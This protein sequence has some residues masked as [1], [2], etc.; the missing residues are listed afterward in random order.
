MNKF[1][2]DWPK[3]PKAKHKRLSDCGLIAWVKSN[4]ATSLVI[5]ALVW[6]VIVKDIL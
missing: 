1:S 2:N 6:I 4:R 5:V 3:H